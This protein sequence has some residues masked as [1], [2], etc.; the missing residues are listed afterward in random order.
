ML[1]IYIYIYIYFCE[2]DAQEESEGRMIRL[3]TLIELEF[4]NYGF[5]SSNF[6]IRAFRACALIETRRRAPRR[7]IRGKS[8]DSKQ[9][10][11]QSAVPSPPIYIYIYI[12]I[13]MS[14]LEEA[15]VPR[16]QADADAQGADARDHLDRD[17]T[18]IDS[19]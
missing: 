2:L 19:Y 12:Y 17:L 3:E 4:T 5:S 15:P 10:I 14:P 16:L 9:R 7:A 11:S 8:S 1:C 6:S 13:Y 18:T